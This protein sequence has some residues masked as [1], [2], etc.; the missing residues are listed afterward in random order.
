M[1]HKRYLTSVSHVSEDLENQT[2][3]QHFVKFE[4]ETLMK[5]INQKSGIAREKV[6]Y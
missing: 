5:I 4:H 2:F 3:D 1:G 6:A